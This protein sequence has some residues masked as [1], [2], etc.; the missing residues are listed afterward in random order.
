MVVVGA[1]L[2]GLVAASELEAAGASV[3]VV[4]A[5]PRV[6]GRTRSAFVH[7]EAADLG[8]QFV[9][10]DHRGMRTLAEALGLRLVPASLGARPFLWRLGGGEQRVGFW[11]PLS[12]REFASLGRALVALKRLS[13]RVDP[14]SP[15][16][17]PDA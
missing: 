4:E 10:P 16:R 12:L 13:L 14:V 1:G 17:S 5:R 9:G 6:G 11:P 2:S 15:W 3:A 7:G 8:G